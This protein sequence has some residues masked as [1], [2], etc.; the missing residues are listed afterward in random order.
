M[1]TLHAEENANALSALIARDQLLEAQLGQMSG[2]H[3][4]WGKLLAEARA[5]SGEIPRVRAQTM[6]EMI[7]KLRALV[8]AMEAEDGVSEWEMA[9]VQSVLNDAIHLSAAC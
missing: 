8:Q 5:V 3:P 1:K 9:M 2:R 7:W 4:S 6:G